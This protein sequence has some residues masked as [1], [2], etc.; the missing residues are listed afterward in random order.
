[1]RVVVVL[2]GCELIAPIIG[3]SKRWGIY[4]DHERPSLWNI[5]S[6]VLKATGFT[7]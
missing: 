7:R 5:M 1:M 4:D 6:N 3:P 2:D